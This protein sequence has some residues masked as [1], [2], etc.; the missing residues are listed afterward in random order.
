MS[1]ISVVEK[2]LTKELGL[3]PCTNEDAIFSYTINAA[4]KSA[5]CIFVNVTLQLKSCADEILNKICKLNTH[6]T[7]TFA[8]D[9]LDQNNLIAT[10]NFKEIEIPCDCEKGADFVE[11]IDFTLTKKD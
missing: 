1:L 6:L 5:C 4:R 8:A 11:E 9:P 3:A 10:L 2:I 7:W